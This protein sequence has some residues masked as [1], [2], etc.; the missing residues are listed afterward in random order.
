MTLEHEG[1]A[2]ARFAGQI[3]GSAREMLKGK[4]VGRRVAYYLPGLRILGC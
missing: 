2:A 1:H 3:T 4:S